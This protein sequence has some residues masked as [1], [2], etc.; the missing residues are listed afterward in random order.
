MIGFTR[1]TYPHIAN[2][3]NEMSGKGKDTVKPPHICA[4]VSGNGKSASS[5]KLVSYLEAAGAK[6]HVFVEEPVN[7]KL[8]YQ[9]TRISDYDKAALMIELKKAWKVHKSEEVEVNLFFNNY[10]NKC[11]QAQSTIG[12]VSFSFNGKLMQFKTK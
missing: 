11:V 4:A 12:G 3:V 9:M 6:V 5:E 10:L 1:V 2:M 7:S 8:A